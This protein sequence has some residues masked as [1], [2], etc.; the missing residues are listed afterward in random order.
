MLCRFDS[1]SKDTRRQIHCKGVFMLRMTLSDQ[2]LPLWTTTN[3]IHSNIPLLYGFCTNHLK[4]LV[5]SRRK[6]Y[7]SFSIDVLNLFNKFYMRWTRLVSLVCHWDWGHRPLSTR[8]AKRTSQLS[9]TFDSFWRVCFPLSHSSSHFSSARVF[10]LHLAVGFCSVIEGDLRGQILFH[11]N[12]HHM[13]LSLALLQE[14]TGKEREKREKLL[15]FLSFALFSSRSRSELF[16]AMHRQTSFY[17]SSSTFLLPSRKIARRQREKN[18]NSRRERKKEGEGERKR[19]IDQGYI[20]H[21]QRCI[22][23]HNISVTR[24]YIHVHTCLLLSLSF[25]SSLL[26]LTTMID[27]RTTLVRYRVDGLSR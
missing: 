11:N 10:R 14:E 8:R 6:D 1:G 22:D 7:Y 23:T 20:N 19:E 2:S 27:Q 24:W 13:T 21:Q 16:V 15:D 25:L 17:Y 26:T 4:D 3:K 9:S 12:N 5:I 18:P